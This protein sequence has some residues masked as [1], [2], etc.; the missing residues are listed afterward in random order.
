[1][2]KHFNITAGDIMYMEELRKQGLSNIQIAHD[3][4]ISKETVRRHIGNQGKKVR[5]EYGSIVTHPVGE[6]FL[7][8]TTIPDQI[9]TLK[10]IPETVAEEKAVT[11]SRIVRTGFINSYAGQEA[12]YM[13]DSAGYVR[14]TNRKTHDTFEFYF[15]E[16]KIFVEELTELA[17]SIK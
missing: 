14:I 5:A 16:F 13:V 1:M 7:D 2:A 10:D 12:D 11:H 9:V 3:M 4:G 6:P 17:E 15:D 8:N